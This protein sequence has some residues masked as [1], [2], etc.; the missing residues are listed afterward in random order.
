MRG[1][2]VLP[3]HAQNK[4]SDFCAPLTSFDWCEADPKHLG[5]SSIDTTCTI[6]DL[7]VRRG[8]L[9]VCAACSQ[10]ACAVGLGAAAL[11]V[12]RHAPLR[13]PHCAWPR[14]AAPLRL[15]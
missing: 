2:T 9:P 13:A 1:T 5:T 15:R 12:P 4:Q 6:W 7:E 10:A 14:G 8:W 3:L 11:S